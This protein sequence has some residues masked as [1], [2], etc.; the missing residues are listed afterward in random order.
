LH[1]FPF[2]IS[3]IEIEQAKTIYSGY[4]YVLLKL[5]DSKANTIPTCTSDPEVREYDTEQTVDWLR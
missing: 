2:G 3:F 5:S 4:R 1:H